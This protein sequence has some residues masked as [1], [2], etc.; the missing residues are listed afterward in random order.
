MGLFDLFVLNVYSSVSFVCEFIVMPFFRCAFFVCV[1]E[2]VFFMSILIHKQVQK[3]INCC[4]IF[5]N[6]ILHSCVL[7]V[8]LLLL[9][10]HSRFNSCLIQRFK[11]NMYERNQST[12]SYN[13]KPV[14]VCGSIE[15]CNNYYWNIKTKQSVE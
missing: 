11:L 6:L 2:C 14:G 9:S 13:A 5:A 8:K 15:C 3:Y 12:Q 10:E 1:I 7:C 4:D